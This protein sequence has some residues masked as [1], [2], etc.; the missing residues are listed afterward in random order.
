MDD[1]FST[2][3]AVSLLFD[4]VR[5]GN[6]IID[7]GGDAS[8]IAGS[9]TEIADVLGLDFDEP[10]EDRV[11]PALAAVAAEFGVDGEGSAR[12]MVERLVEMR[13]EARLVND[14]AT[15]DRIRHR[16]AEAGVSLEDGPD[17]TTWL[18]R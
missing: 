13:S 4:L 12:V 11:T 10:A 2:P 6:R 18:R 9:V 3:Q 15:A 14:F 5:E 8:S 17:G 1:D 16:L 7:E